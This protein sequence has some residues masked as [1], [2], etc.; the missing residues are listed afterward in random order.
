M[1][2]KNSKR[3]QS[4]VTGLIRNIVKDV[5]QTLTGKKNLKAF[6]MSRKAMMQLMAD[7]EWKQRFSNL[8]G[9]RPIHAETVLETLRPFMAHWANEPEKG[10]LQ[11]ICDDTVAGMYPDN[12]SAESSVGRQKAKRFFL[13]NYRAL[14]Q[15]EMERDGF[16][17]EDHITFLSA[18]ETEGCMTAAEYERLRI[19]WR[20][21]Y[22]Y[23]FMR[24]SREITPF[25][26]VGHIAGVHFT[27]L[28]IG[29]QLVGTDIPVDLALVSG[30][31]AGHDLGKYGCTAQEAKRIPYLHYYYTEQLLKREKMPMIAHI[32][33]NHSTWDLELE[34][35]SIESLLLIYADFRVKSS[36]EGGREQV[37]FYSLTQAFDVILNKLDNV[38]AAK[39]HR[40]EKVYAKLKDFENYLVDL[41]VE[42]DITKRPAVLPGCS[43]KDSALLM[44]QE[45]VERIKYTAIAHNIKIMGI[46][47]DESAFGSLLEAARSE[48]QWKSQRAY[49][50]ILSEY[51]TYMTKPEKQMTLHFL[52]DL[53]SHR[54]GDIRR[55]A[56]RLMGMIIAGYDDVY[57][58]ELPEGAAKTAVKREAVDIWDTYLHKIVFPDY[59]VTDQHRSWIGYTLKVIVQALVEN[60]EDRDVPLFMEKYFQ[61]YRMEELADS[62]VFVLLDSVINIPRHALCE[63]EMLSVLQFAARVSKRDSVEIKA[64]A[65]RAAEYI[66][67]YLAT[68][69]AISAVKEIISHGKAFAGNISVTYLVYQILR[70]LGQKAEAAVY[71]DRIEKMERNGKLGEAVSGISR[72]NLKVGTPWVLK[73]INMDFLLGNALSLGFSSRNF[74]LA[75][76]FSN[77]IKVSERV[78]VR[79]R[80]GK[81]LI[82]IAATLPIEQINELVI[83]LTKGL[84]IGEYQFSKYI[85]AYLGELAL[86]LEPDELDE[87][88]DNLGE[89][90]VSAND[91]VA[92]VA[93]DTVGE[94]VKKYAS[95]GYRYEE[96]KQNYD[97][98]KKK[99]LGLLLKGLADYHE[100]V[101]Q[102]A[103]MVIG[104]Y[105]FGDGELAQEEKF[106]AFQQIYKK[107]L[108]LI[109]SID[110]YDMNFFNNAAALNHI[111]RFISEYKFTSGEMKLP[112]NDRIAFFPGTFDPFSLS[113]KG[114]VQAIRDEGFEVY[115]AIDEFSWSKKT[116]ARKI[117][118]QII[119][120]S[121]AD[122]TGVFLFPD[123][124]PVNIANPADLRRLKS[125]FP[126]RNLYMVVGSDVIANASSY[127]AEPSSDSIH[128]M[129]HIVFRRETMEG[130]K[131]SRERLRHAYRSITGIIRELKLPVYLEDISSTRIRENIDRGRD[132]AN[133]IDPVA[134]NFIYDNSLYLREP[135]YKNVFEIRNISFEPLQNRGS[136]ILAEMQA[137]M[138]ERGLNVKGLREYLD[139]PHVRSALIRDGENRICAIAAAGELE[140]GQLYETFR[141]V[142]IASY[143][144]EKA[145]GRM[146]VIRGLYCSSDK[147][148]GDLVQIMMTEV[149][150]E[151]VAKDI[152]YAIYHSLEEGNNKNIVDVLKRQG[153]TEMVI[154]GNEMGVYE[155]NMK[156]PIAVIEN[157]DTVLKAP[158]NTNPRILDVL[159]QTHANMQQALTGLNPGNLVLS[160]NAGIMHQK[161][162][163]MVT[164]TNGVPGFP[165][166]ERKLGDYMCVPFGKILRGMAVPNTVTKTLHTEKM[167]S[168]K[169]DRFT[170]EEY[171]MYAAI[172]DQVRTIKSFNRQV[173]LV[174]DLL[175]KGYRMKALDPVFKENG[176]EIRKLITGL[177]SGQGKD[178]MT[179]QGRE[180]ESAYFIPNL[181]S[182]FVESTLCPFIGGDGVQS[183]EKASA[184]LIPSINLLLPFAAPGFLSAFPREAVYELSRVCLENAAKIFSVLEKEYQVLFE[185]KLTLKRL[186][187]AI[188][189]PRMPNG[190]NRVSADFNLSPSVYIA[191]Y[192]ERLARLESALK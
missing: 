141:D 60:T 93:L 59:M 157:M 46:F 90:I 8:A 70:Q 86:Y 20:E 186:S 24:I 51:F 84:E 119:S 30:A 159:E 146:L 16:S 150:A 151:A 181:K 43:R 131:E 149:L 139:M 11:E 172:P 137:D 22:I 128:S 52:Y 33:S 95:Y 168:S 32:A 56:G 44:G 111:Y 31:A 50:N 110:G 133:L 138:R 12:F 42:T 85:P 66:S 122:E 77:L 48:K 161:I 65:L 191:D 188:Q 21:H 125:L 190:A 140:T 57:R 27:A 94:V 109:P 183:E 153:F 15:Y 173:I 40:Y 116:Q 126:G 68:E 2:A 58:K 13:E 179:I 53:L 104:Q 115:L 177:L 80:A 92:S 72:E 148:M 147:D 134:Q 83:E 123:N 89:L 117:R 99:M 10:W 17:P 14:L 167:F 38:D 97:A 106:D 75:T 108:T 143:L 158:F 192:M 152:T 162:V 1:Y 127:K 61:L 64:G 120:M 169:L 176:L 164:K 35:L 23:E 49:L 187:D 45:A 34:N 171:P 87:F 81:S 78:T 154:D 69:E 36:R 18:A 19:F 156:E 47:N 170:I 130:G 82:K 107:L 28:F 67:E 166:P 178:L 184:N 4:G 105:I 73:I 39:R 79:H 112:E 6:G 145:T 185:R 113:H 76:H 100:T 124:F 118:R 55:Q 98:R 163:N 26:T 74:H 3:I 144:R 182:W 165:L 9:Q 189:S 5:Q 142:R 132:I 155:V 62:A 91:K 114:I 101:S 103:F 29:K 41:G 63:A 129:N 54:E 160:F 96:G 71:Y 175:H 174:D 7:F 37:H 88:I 102:E 180:V 135:Q 25:N 121:V 136:G